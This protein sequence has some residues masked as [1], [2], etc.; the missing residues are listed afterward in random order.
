MMNNEMQNQEKLSVVGEKCRD[1]HA[2]EEEKVYCKTVNRKRF[3]FPILQRQNFLLLY[4]ERSGGHLSEHVDTHNAG[5]WSLENP[6]E[7]IESQRDSPKLSVFCA[8]SRR[9]VF[10][11]FVFGEP[12]VTGSAYFDAVQLCLFPQLK[13]SESDIFIWQQDGALPHWHLSVRNWLNITVLDQWIFCEWPHDKA[14]F[15]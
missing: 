5:I 14:C 13:G 10:V 7:V 3:V 8:V 1:V 12:T 9:K 4:N 2:W 15:A 11:L 6:H